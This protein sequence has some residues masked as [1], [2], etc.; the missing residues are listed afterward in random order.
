MEHWPTV[1][2]SLMDED[3][4]YLHHQSLQIAGL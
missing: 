4:R 1:Q 3:D 2:Q